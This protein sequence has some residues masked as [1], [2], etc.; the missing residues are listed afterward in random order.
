MQNIFET[1][2][3]E[4]ELALANDDLNRVSRRVMD[5]THDFDC[6][7]EHK[8][9]SIS[10]R[11][12]YNIHK[13][14]GKSGN[15]NESIKTEYQNLISAIKNAHPI[16]VVLNNQEEII[17]K[18]NDISK[19]LGS[20]NLQKI[21]L[22]LQRGKIIGLVG[23]NG[24]GKT[25]LLRVLSGEISCDEGSVEF[26]SGNKLLNTWEEIKTEVAFIPQRI[27]RWWG[28]V[29]DQI[30]FS[31]AI[32]GITGEQNL[33]ATN[34]IIHRLG[35][36]NFKNHSWGQLSSGYKLRVEIAKTLVWNPKVLMLDE[37]LANLDLMA[38]ELLLQDLK[39]LTAS[40]KH[41]VTLILTS[42]QLHEVETIADT[43]IFLKNGRSVFN[44]NTN[45]LASLEN[46]Y[47]LEIDGK[48]TY[49]E[50]SGCLEG[51]KVK[52]EKNSLGYTILLSKNH[53][54][55]SFFSKLM[56]CDLELT[57]FRNISNSTKK[58]FNDKY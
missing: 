38:Q 31:A 4:L 49:D 9:L 57:Y 45:D 24:N 52:I 46:D 39:D 48:F 32:K 3:K 1:R 53:T 8:S 55:K 12:T 50:L 25:T 37:P 54:I 19:S 30:S 16:L 29:F 5:L 2:I 36:S 7:A 51:W 23:E 13:E 10:L 22:Q 34:F 28:N 33:Y 56:D 11:E 27:D 18:A 26:F 17:C 20:F 21:S 47:T 40:V 41:P 6:S 15:Q 14:L 44:G 58:L 42:Q 43:V 35:L